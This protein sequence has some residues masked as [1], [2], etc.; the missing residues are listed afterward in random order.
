MSRLRV[1]P[2]PVVASGCSNDP[3]QPAQA[4]GGFTIN[5]HPF[6]R[7]AQGAGQVFKDVNGMEVH[8]GWYV[9]LYDDG[10]PGCLQFMSNAQRGT[11]LQFHLPN[12]P[13]G[14]HDVSLG[15][16]VFWVNG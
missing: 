7:L 14:P 2:L 15:N 1:L 3:A 9:E 4:D 11:V 16:T 13:L 6:R 5:G 8:A 10:S 12:D